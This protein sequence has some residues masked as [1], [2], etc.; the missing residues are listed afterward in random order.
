VP[1]GPGYSKL[2]LD[3]RD[4][5]LAE[6]Q[7]AFRIGNERLRGAVEA[8]GGGE[9]VPFLCECIDDTC[10]GRVDLTLEEYGGIRRHENRFVLLRDHPT[11]PGERIVQD[12]GFHQVVE[13]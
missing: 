12:D 1:D 7:R 2:A 11:L 10:M 13:K 8:R 9:P 4:Q 6:N 5:R 3:S